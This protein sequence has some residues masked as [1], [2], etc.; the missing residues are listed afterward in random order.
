MIFISFSA[1]AQEWQ[2]VL[3]LK[4]GSVIRGVLIEQIPN[5]SV[6]IQ[7]SDGSVF[8]YEMEDV[9]K[10][11][12]EQKQKT[13]K[14][15][16]TTEPTGKLKYPNRGYRGIL[17]LSYVTG[18]DVDG[19]S[20]TTVHGAQIFP[21]LFVGGGIGIEDISYLDMKYFGNNSEWLFVPVFADVRFDFVKYK[22]SP[23]VD[24]RLGVRFGDVSDVY[25]A[26]SVGC[27]FSHFNLSLGYEAIQYS[28]TLGNT[29]KTTYT[30]YY[31]ALAVRL[32]FDMGAR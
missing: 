21:K 2:D 27:R 11:A 20:F 18:N 13:E 30:G 5:V 32:A 26:P 15:K 24:L 8:A 29:T 28:Y 19:F 23:F 6:K 16:K 14:E 1:F 3:Y 12:K 17:S 7:T 9:E 4:N 25:F 31:G 22:I 10:M